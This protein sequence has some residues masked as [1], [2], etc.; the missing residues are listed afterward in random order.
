MA[1]AVA[2][3]RG[4]GGGGRQTVSTDGGSLVAATPAPHPE[5]GLR[6]GVVPSSFLRS[7]TSIS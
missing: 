6:V 4:G 5:R 1:A 3:G 7:H 2:R